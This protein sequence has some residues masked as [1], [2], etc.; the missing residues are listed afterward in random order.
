MLLVSERTALYRL[1]AA[2]DTLL[3]VGVS[4]HIEARWKKH[5]ALKWWWPEV[6][7]KTVEWL[8]SRDAAEAAEL[9]AIRTERPV[10]NVAR[11]PWA[12]PPRSLAVDEFTI[13]Q[14][15][16]QLGEIADS[17]RLLRKIVVIVHR[18][19]ARTPHA[20]IVPL[21]VGEAIEAAGGPDAALKL[22]APRSPR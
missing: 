15:S 11:S 16:A 5:A 2:D 12:S 22:L 9:E 3:Y 20:A 21:D 17:V 18:D 8:E 7:R 4:S 1:F 6:A 13:G 10:H 14:A 19:K